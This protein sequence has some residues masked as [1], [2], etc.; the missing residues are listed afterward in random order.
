MVDVLHSLFGFDIR[1]FNCD[2]QYGLVPA[3]TRPFYWLIITFRSP[4]DCRRRVK[5]V[6]SAP[7]LLLQ[8]AG[9]AGAFGQK[10]EKG[11]PAVIEPVR[12]RELT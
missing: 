12:P 9:A 2:S 5:N 10:G 8:V 6:A 4:V 3:L 1:S 7:A 11:E